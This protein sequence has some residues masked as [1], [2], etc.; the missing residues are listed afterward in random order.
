M[1]AQVAGQGYAHMR[2]ENPRPVSVFLTDDDGLGVRLPWRMRAL[3]K[4]RVLPA[5]RRWVKGAGYW[6]ITAAGYRALVK[7]GR[8]WWL[9]PLPDSVTLWLE[10]NK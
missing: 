4:G 1:A 9:A 8:V 6:R 2:D 5:D 7:D 3:M 10:Q